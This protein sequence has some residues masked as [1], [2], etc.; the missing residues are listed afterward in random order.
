MGTALGSIAK[1]AAQQL[2]VKR[3][4]I[5]GGDTSSYA[6]RAMEIEAVEMIAP[7]IIGAPLCKAISKNKNINGLEVN[8]KGGQV[9]ADNYFEILLNSS[10]P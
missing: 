4:V 9:G 7:L 3:I 5:A 6:A 8:F 2:L 1:D 10:Q